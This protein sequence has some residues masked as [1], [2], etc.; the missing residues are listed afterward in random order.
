MKIK[1][2]IQSLFVEMIYK[3]LTLLHQVHLF[4]YPK[5]FI[6]FLNEIIQQI[7]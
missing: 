1:L 6:F 3:Y 4:S 7:L 5:I 2:F